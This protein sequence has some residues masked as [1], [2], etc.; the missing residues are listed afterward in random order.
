MIKIVVLTVWLVAMIFTG[1]YWVRRDTYGEE[2]SRT[3]SL[4]TSLE[5]I[6]IICFVASTIIVFGYL[7]FAIGDYTMPLQ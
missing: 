6:G 4:I 5:L 1:S 3:A 7:V 2:E